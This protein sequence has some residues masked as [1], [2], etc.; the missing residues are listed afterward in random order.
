MDKNTVKLYRVFFTD[1]NQ[2]L[3]Q[4]NNILEIMKYIDAMLL[5]QYKAEDI[6]KIEEVDE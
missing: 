4:G 6:Y 2:K 3:Y 5:G 1:G